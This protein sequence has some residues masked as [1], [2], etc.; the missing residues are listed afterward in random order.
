MVSGV[1]R[2]SRARTSAGT[3]STGLFDVHGATKELSSVEGGNGGV[4]LVAVLHRHKGEPSRVLGV[5]VPHHLALGNLEF[6]ERGA[7]KVK[8]Y[9]AKL[10]EELLEVTVLDA[11]GEARDVEVVSGV[12]LTLALLSTRP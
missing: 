9:S 6:R 5:R 7:E 2:G 10:G 4:C 3:A 12:L 11:G 8:S 1:A